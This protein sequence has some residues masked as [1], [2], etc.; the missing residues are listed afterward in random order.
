MRGVLALICSL[1][2]LLGTAC[3]AAAARA[4]DPYAALLAPAGSC[5]NAEDG[6]DLDVASARTAMLCLTNYARRQRGLA[7]LKLSAVL[8]A[9]G[10]AKLAADVSCGQFS[11]APCGRAF[12]AVFARYLSG[13]AS[14][15]I[16]ENIEWGT[17]SYGSPRQAMNG[18]LHSSGHRAN[19]LDASYAELGIG[20]LPGQSFQGSTGATL[21]SQEFGTRSPR[22]HA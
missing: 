12:D 4:D 9:A 7:P 21:W 15:R 11:H 13:A 20:Y 14:Y 2:A 19:I 10:Q 5:G 17:G 6:L 1:A 18:W 8:H 16:A 22:P 3:A